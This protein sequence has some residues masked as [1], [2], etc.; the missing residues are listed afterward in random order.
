[1]RQ[2]IYIGPG[3]TRGLEE[4]DFAKMG[5]EH[6]REEVFQRGIAREVSDKIADALLTH[7]IIMGEFIELEVD[8]ED[9]EDDEADSAKSTD[10]EKSGDAGAMAD[11]GHVQQVPEGSAKT[12][13]STPRGSNQRRAS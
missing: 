1:M 11:S 2:V 8:D 10:D 5:I 4:A 9:S 7:P 13:G 3:N 6:K 12:S